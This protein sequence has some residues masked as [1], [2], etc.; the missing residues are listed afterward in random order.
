M[1]SRLRL[2]SDTAVTDVCGYGQI[3]LQRAAYSD[4][5][6]VVL[7]AEGSLPID[8]FAVYE[9]PIP[10]EFQTQ[11]GRRRITVTLAY[12]PPVRHSRADY[13]GI[14]M[15]FRLL[16]G[17]SPETVFEHY[18]RR[19]NN[20]G[21]APEI[22]AKYNCDPKPGPTIREKGTLQRAS[23]EF[24]RGIEN[25]GDKYYLVVRCEG[26]WAA[27]TVV[28]QRFAVVV[29]LKHESSIELYQRLRARVRA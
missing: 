19:Q 15:N 3:D 26:G 27:Q 21:A 5:S 8:H 11:P 12:D 20:E 25:Y 9:I 24:K 22:P 10:A 6:R 23:A 14:G 1:V 7:Y 16:R 18:R 2:L 29:E 4:D 17:C 13:L 28:D